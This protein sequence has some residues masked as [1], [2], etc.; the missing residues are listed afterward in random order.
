[1]KGKHVIMARNI[2][3]RNAS[4]VFPLILE[5]VLL[6][7]NTVSS[8]QGDSTLE[9]RN[10]TTT[11][12]NPLERYVVT[13]G[14]KASTIAQIA[15]TMWVLGGRDD[16]TW[17][18]N[19]LPR[20]P[21]FSDNG[22]TWRGAYGPRLRRWAGIGEMCEDCFAPPVDQL[23]YVARL[24]SNETDT[25]RAVMTIYDPT[26]DSS[27]GKDVPCNNWL[28]FIQRDGKLHLNVVARSNDVFWGWSGINAFE[29]SVLLQVMSEISGFQA[30]EL[31]FFTS[32]MH[33]YDRHWDRA[34][35][36]LQ[37]LPAHP[38]YVFGHPLP[39]TV[40]PETGARTVEVLDEELEK[41]FRFERFAR[42]ERAPW[43][44]AEGLKLFNNI[45]SPLFRQWAAAVAWWWTGDEV[46][47][48]YIPDH[49]LLEALWA[50][51]GADRI[52]QG[53][54]HDAVKVPADSEGMSGEV[55]KDPFAYPIRTATGFPEFKKY[56]ADLHAEKH[57]A[58]GDSWKRRGESMGIMANVARKVD[59]L[60]VSD[61][62]ET[63]ADT[64]IDLSVY[65]IKYNLW[66]LEK[67]DYLDAQFGERDLTKDLSDGEAP[68]RHVIERIGIAENVV[69]RMLHPASSA[70]TIEAAIKQIHE[71]FEGME[72]TFPD[73][74]VWTGVRGMTPPRVRSLVEKRF[75]LLW[76]ILNGAITLAAAL[77]TMETASAGEEAWKAGNATRVWKGY[78]N[79]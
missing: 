16:I 49:R 48:Q 51:P 37:D 35:S 75:S 4:S 28:H 45:R 62:Q 76:N 13:P 36:L 40:F 54:Y 53:L 69:E 23:D 1:M 15:E 25:R 70:R 66:L 12:K 56:I 20:A 22:R 19:Y 74:P 71:S 10:L 55:K 17:L 9:I 73:H 7:G 6:D 29:W 31:T 67:Y 2:T 42:E 60:G 57:K 26:W 43:D 78:D 5:Q 61:S 46:A 18:K 21:E 14:R 33:L 3:G 24:I 44:A 39:P 65:L 32:S 34:K 38:K 47:L 58:Y 72:R 77:W 41:W 30:G 79:D 64:A 63:S 50:T 27:D 8:R 59:R 52:R 68:V 11:L